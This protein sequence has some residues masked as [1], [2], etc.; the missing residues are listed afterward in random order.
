MSNQ[1]N[2]NPLGLKSISEYNALGMAEDYRKRIFSMDWVFNKFY[3][4][5]ILVA[6]FSWAVYSLI[7]FLIGLV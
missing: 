7:K 2:L 5:I 4:K 1:E 6:C 3:E